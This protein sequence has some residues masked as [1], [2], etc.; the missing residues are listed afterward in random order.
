MAKKSRDFETMKK[1]L[2]KI[3]PVL[4]E[5]TTE[6]NLST[7][8]AP[9]SVKSNPLLPAPDQSCQECKGLGIIYKIEDG[10]TIPK[11]CKCLLR[12]EIRHYLTPPYADAQYL[13]DEA[14]FS[15]MEG[16]DII[17]QGRQS[18]L[19]TFVKSFLLSTGAEYSHV[20][21]T[22]ADLFQKHFNSAN[23]GMDEWNRILNVDILILYL[24]FDTPNRTYGD[25]FQSV[26]E[27]RNFNKKVTW[28]YSDKSYLS[29]SYQRLYTKEFVDYLKN[30]YALKA[31][32]FRN[33]E[34]EQKD[35]P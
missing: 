11:K 31:I 5:A 1:D 4:E 2:E 32:L 19:K 23:T 21:V 33:L 22:A 14:Y 7:K 35:N 30:K 18:L 3:T 12:K 26:M 17:I 25:I 13:I 20:T 8:S 28:V 6:I 15:A 24:A 34:P 10:K 16:K 27:K 9:V 29:E